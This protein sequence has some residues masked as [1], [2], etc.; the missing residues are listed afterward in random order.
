[1]VFKTYLLP[2]ISICWFQ[3]CVTSNSEK[4]LSSTLLENK[5]KWEAKEPETY[6]YIVMDKCKCPGDLP[7]PFKI[8][9]SKDSL[10]KVAYIRSG[11]DSILDKKHYGYLSIDSVFNRLASVLSSDVIRSEITYDP[12]FGYP[13]NA[14]IDINKSEADDDIFI[15]IMNFLP[16]ER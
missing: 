13:R 15:S 16:N 12:E 10:L 5:E 3:G 4:G 14:T 7:G 9:A 11:P 6:G 8:I 2:I 1:M